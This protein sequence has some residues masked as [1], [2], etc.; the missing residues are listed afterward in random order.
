M[1]WIGDQIYPVGGPAVLDATFGHLI[2]DEAWMMLENEVR[3]DVQDLQPIR[4]IRFHMYHDFIGS[5][6][7]L[8]RRK[9]ED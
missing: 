2:A 3:W 8:P 5:E 4:F 1:R 7:G 6:R 9:V